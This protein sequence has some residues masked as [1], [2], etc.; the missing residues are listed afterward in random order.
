M[1]P[2]EA[3]IKAVVQYTPAFLCRLFLQLLLNLL[4]CGSAVESPLC[5]WQHLACVSLVNSWWMLAV[6][7]QGLKRMGLTGQVA[8]FLNTFHSY[9]SNYTIEKEALPLIWALQLVMGVVFW[10]F[11]LNTTPLTS[12]KLL[13]CSNQCLLQCALFLQCYF[14]DIKHAKGKDTIIAEAHMCSESTSVSVCQCLSVG[15]TN[16][17]SL[18]HWPYI[19]H[20]DDCF[21]L[22][23]TKPQI[24]PFIFLLPNTLCN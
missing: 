7:V 21:S 9:Q 10:W 4:Y 16:M 1:C 20:S 17:A 22:L 11:I 3:K 5:S 18:T 15:S 19:P 12:L 8:T 14:S 13:K 6:W 2:V 24:Q 23:C